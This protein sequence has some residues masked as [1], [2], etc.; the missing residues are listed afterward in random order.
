MAVRVPTAWLKKKFTIFS[1]KGETSGVELGTTERLL[2]RSQLMK[3]KIKICGMSI[4]ASLAGFN[5]TAQPKYSNWSE[6]V[7]LGPVIN[8]GFNDQ[9]AALSK[10]GLSL[11]FTSNRPG[12][13]GADDLWVSRRASVEDPWG[14]PQN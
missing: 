2:Q 13:Y 5:L 4:V 8:T 3:T 9:H 6:P 7:N 10:N 14:A 1:K 11:Y 12:G